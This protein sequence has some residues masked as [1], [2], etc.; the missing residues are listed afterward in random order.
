MGGE[1]SARIPLTPADTECHAG[2]GCKPL[3]VPVPHSF[4]TTGI[5]PSNR[6][7]A[8]ALSADALEAAV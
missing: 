7:F 2:L 4:Q 3:L 6:Y 5:S 1:V 8:T